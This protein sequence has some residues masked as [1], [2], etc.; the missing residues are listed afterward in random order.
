MK[1][2][3]IQ[4]NDRIKKLQYEKLT[5]ILHVVSI[6]RILAAG[7]LPEELLGGWYTF[8][9]AGLENIDQTG[10]IT[11]QPSCYHCHERKHLARQCPWQR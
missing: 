7:K 6:N 9:G 8:G 1:T 2:L 4:L 5:E 11:F 3:S 10:T